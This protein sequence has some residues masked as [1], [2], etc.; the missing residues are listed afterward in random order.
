MKALACKIF[1][2]RKTTGQAYQQT[3]KLY[4]LS[5]YTQTTVVNILL[6]PCVL[7]CFSEFFDQPHTGNKTSSAL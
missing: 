2:W 6:F 3:R 7:V 1:I 4:L 5:Y